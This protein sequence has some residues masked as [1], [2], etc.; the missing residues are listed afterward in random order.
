[1]FKVKK[2]KIMWQVLSFA[3]M[4]LFAASAMA[5]DNFMTNA[6]TTDS[7]F[8]YEV[9]VTP[10][11]G[12]VGAG[13]AG[14][15]S[16]AT[17]AKFNKYGYMEWAR[18]FADVSTSNCNAVAA[19]D[20]GI[21]LTGRTA[22]A[23]LWVAKV[24]G[25]GKVLWQ[26]EYTY[27]G[28]SSPNIMG[29]SI[30]A[31]QDGGCAVSLRI[32]VGTI[33]GVYYNYDQGLAKI[34]A[35]GSL[36]WVKFYGTENYDMSG[37]MIETKDA[38]GNMDGYLMAIAEDEWGGVDLDNE[39]ILIKT[40]TDGVKLWVYAYAGYNTADPPV[41][42]G[43][44]FVK[45]ICQTADFGYA[46]AGQSYSASDP[47]W[48][49]RVAYLLKV[50]NIGTKLWA[51]R[52]G[53]LSVDPGANAFIYGDVAQAKDNTDLIVAGTYHTNRHWLLRFAQ[54]G[55]LL[56]ECLYPE[57][58]VKD[59]LRSV[60][61]TEDGG[62]VASGD[63]ESFGAGDYDAFLMKFD[64]NLEFPGTDCPGCTDPGSEID[65]M[66]FDRQDVTE[67]C[68]EIL[69]TDWTTADGTAEP[70]DPGF[71]LWYCALNND[72]DGDS[73]FD[74]LDNCCL[75]PNPLQE[76]TDGDGYGNICDCDL[77]NDCVVGM[78]DYSSFCSAWQTS[79]PDADFDSDGIV[80]MSDYGIF[81]ARWLDE[82]PFE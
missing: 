62:G 59:R 11:G 30:A 43:N 25:C 24:A 31:T 35:D 17:V 7:D 22:S 73:V 72:T 19:G 57:V 26:K 54:D 69:S 12:Y 32:K 21:F 6:A 79:D 20:D 47:G 39:V 9:A 8:F 4:F 60:A 53:I 40:N 52:F 2:S 33:D 50:D 15:G 16:N 68:H 34:A 75:T 3:A 58:S 10:D 5:S 36:S 41:P 45:G 13:K 78:S 74:H 38:S 63:S 61:A 18:S 56:K 77:D 28:Y 1:M 49:R 67:N 71:D 82:T 48:S 37:Q 81:C 76:D 29:I 66:R 46:V 64:A 65:D 80:G 44:E 23:T 27:H 51:K 14:A 70:S 55:S 42:D